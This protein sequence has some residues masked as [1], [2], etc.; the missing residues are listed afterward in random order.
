[1]NHGSGAVAPVSTIMPVR[2]IATAT[3]WR[4]VRQVARLA[5]QGLD[6]RSSVRRPVLLALELAAGAAT[7]LCAVKLW[8]GASAQALYMGQVALWLWLTLLAISAG[9]ATAE[10]GTLARSRRLRALQSDLPAK[11]LIMPHDH[12]EDWLYETVPSETLDAGDVVLVQAGDVIPADGEVIAGVAKV[13]E[14]AITGESAPVLRESG[15]DRSA[16]IGGTRVLS[17][18]LKVKVTADFGHGMFAQVSALT[19]GARS[20][21]SAWPDGQRRGILA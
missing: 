5:L 21:P 18:W 6:P 8:H 4:F 12:R 20:G 10:A 9:V 11:V 3:D 16:V 17:D 15:G 14:S 7:I 2:P 13:D 19:S 1:M